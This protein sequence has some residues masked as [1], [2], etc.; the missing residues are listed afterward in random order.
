MYYFYQALGRKF[1]W[2]VIAGLFWDGLN[3]KLALVGIGLW[4]CLRTNLLLYHWLVCR[5]VGG[6]C[7]FDDL[8][9]SF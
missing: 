4:K 7:G 8:Y 2:P 6:H 1:N 5:L 9:P 3:R